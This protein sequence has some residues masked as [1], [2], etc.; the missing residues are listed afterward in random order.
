MNSAMKCSV[1][2]GAPLGFER[3]ARR[4][5]DDAGG[6]AVSVQ[7][8]AVIDDAPFGSSG[9][10]ADVN[11]LRFAS[12]FADFVRER[13]GQVDLQFQ[14]RKPL[15]HRHRR[16]DGTAEGGIEERRCETAVRHASAVIEPFFDGGGKYDAARID[17]DQAD[18]EQ[19]QHRRRREF[20]G[21]HLPEVV[22]AAQ[23]AA[24]VDDRHDFATAAEC[25]SRSTRYRIFPTALIGRP[26]RISI[27]A[28]TLYPV[29]LVLQCAMMS[30]ALAAAPGFKATHAFTISPWYGSG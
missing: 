5:D 9:A 10:A 3:A 24:G 2:G 1:S 22:D 13:P 11:H 27:S 26:S 19:R 8:A 29:R 4:F 18:A 21:D 30:S 15:A 7:L 17:L 25:S 12:H 14:R 28:G 23:A 6:G 16:I 20:A